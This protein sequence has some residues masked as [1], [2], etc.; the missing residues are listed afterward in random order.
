[1][2]WTLPKF[3]KAQ[4]TNPAALHNL[5]G[6]NRTGAIAV[7]HITSVQWRGSTKI[8]WKTKSYVRSVTLEES[9]CAV[10]SAP[11]CFTFLATFQLSRSFPGKLFASSCILKVWMSVSACRHLSWVS[12]LCFQWRLVLLSLPWPVIAREWNQTG[13]Q[14]N[15]D[16]V[17][18]WRRNSSGRQASQQFFLKKNLYI[19]MKSTLTLY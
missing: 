12:G 4:T 5:Q 10:I 17:R 8:L 18:F 16:A 9:C 7:F 6:V 1:M 13:S 14:N 15:K 3:H 19:N 11:S 2:R